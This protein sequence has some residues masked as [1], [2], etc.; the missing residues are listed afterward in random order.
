MKYLFLLKNRVYHLYTKIF[1]RFRLR[2]HL[3]SVS[4]FLGLLV[5]SGLVALLKLF[6][7]VHKHH[8]LSAAQKK[9]S[10]FELLCK[11]LQQSQKSAAELMNLESIVEK[12]TIKDLPAKLIDAKD[13]ACMDILKNRQEELQLPGPL[14]CKTEKASSPFFKQVQY[15]FIRPLEMTSYNLLNM[16]HSIETSDR[17]DQFFL[18]LHIQEKEIVKGYTTC[19]CEGSILKRE[20]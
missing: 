18:K 11:T 7:V 13:L 1:K 5:F 9:Y 19:V 14:L 2:E 17:G 15:D 6:D 4:F 12:S 3:N 10:H 8:M 20:K 16:I